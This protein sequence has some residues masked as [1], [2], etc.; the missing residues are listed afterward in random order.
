MRTITI[1]SS[2]L[3]RL[4]VCVLAPLLFIVSY[5]SPH[6][7]PR[8]DIGAADH[9][10]FL[11]ADPVFPNQPPSCPIC[12]RNYWNINSCS[13]AA[14]V[15][16]NFSMIIFNPGAFIDVIRCA[17]TDTFQSTYPQCVDCFI[18]T[19]Q[20]QFLDPSTDGQNLP[21]VVDG[22]RRICALQSVLL[23][24]AATAD[25][26]VTPTSTRRASA[27]TTSSAATNAQPYPLHKPIL[28]TLAIALV[29]VCM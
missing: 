14:P 8:S 13:Q 20:T 28:V 1:M 3:L 10:L 19:N 25:G 23:G 18:L 5:A 11:R 21:A 24:G 12:S 17:C 22:M 16:A 9:A 4:T 27:P 7:N 6:G 26:Q 29:S 2:A 15:L